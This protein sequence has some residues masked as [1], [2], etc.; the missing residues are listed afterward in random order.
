MTIPEILQ[1][2]ATATHPVAAAIH[3]GDNSKVLAIAFRQGMMLKGHKSPIPAHL[4]VLTGKVLYQEE[5]LSRTLEQY[6]STPIPEGE[7][8]AVQALEDSLCLLIQG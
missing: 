5:N 2:V 7:M 4:L 3:K 6:D 8:H 1:Q